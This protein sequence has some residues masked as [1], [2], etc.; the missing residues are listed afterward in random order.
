MRLTRS[1][2]RVLDTIRN[3][4]Y[5]WVAA[6]YPYLARKTG[7]GNFCSER[8]NNKTFTSL[9]DCRAI[10]RGEDGRYYLKETV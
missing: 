3:G 7:D 2:L 6:G 1:Q 8:L 4:G 5:I 10:S 9:L